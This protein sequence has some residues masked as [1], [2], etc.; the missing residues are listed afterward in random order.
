MFVLLFVD[1]P[2]RRAVVAVVALALAAC[3]EDAAPVAGQTGADT[4]DTPLDTSAPTD[5]GGGADTAVAELSLDIPKDVAVPVDAAKD[6]AAA[7]CP[8]CPCA[9]PDDC[10]SGFCI[11]SPNGLQCAKK[12]EDN[13]CPKDYKCASMPLGSGDL[14]NI[15]VPA[16]ANLCNPC[17]AN[18]QCQGPGSGGARCV[19]FGNAGA[20]C[21]EACTGNI[22]CLEGY[23]CLDTKDLAGNQSKQCVVKGGAACKCSPAALKY[24]L[25]TVCYKDTGSAKCAGKRICLGA[26]K[27]GAPTGGGLTP[28]L[29]DAP[30]AEKCDGKDNDC[31]GQTDESACDDGNP[32]TDDNCDPKA[33]CSHTNNNGFCDSDGSVCTKDDACANGKCLS[34]KPLNCDDNNV[35]TTDSCDAKSGCKNVNAEGLGCNVDDNPCTVGDACKEGKCVAGPPKACSNDQP[36]IE[37]KCNLFKGG[38]CEYKDKNGQPCDDGN[39]CTAGEACIADTCA[40]LKV[41]DCDDKNPCTIDTCDKKV[42]CTHTPAA[43]GCDDGDKCTTKDTCSNGKCD[44]AA[45]DASKYCNDNNGCTADTCNPA[46]GCVNKPNQGAACDDGNACSVGDKCDVT[47]SCLPGNNTCACTTDVDCVAMDDSNACNGV[48]YCDKSGPQMQCKIKP[49]SIVTCDTSGDNTC[50]KTVCDIATGKCAPNLQPDG[51]PCP[52]DDS[53]CTV[54]DGCKSGVCTAGKALACDDKNGCTIDTCDAKAGCQHAVQ[55][56]G[57]CDADGDACTTGDACKAGVCEAGAKKSC[58]DGEACTADTCDAK[59]GD[60]ANKPAATTTC[61]DGNECTIGDACGTDAKSGKY[62]CVPGKG[63]NCDDGNPCTTDTCDGKTGCKSTIVAD[64]Q[65]PC[66][67]GDPTTQ[68][69]GICKP[70]VQTC[71]A[72]GKLGACKG[73]VLPDKT[74][75]CDGKDN[76]CN[77]SAD[78]GCAP[79]GWGLRFANADVAGVG[80]NLAV[81][82][83]VGGGATA[84]KSA[85]SKYAVYWGFIA[86]LKG[87]VK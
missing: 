34:G 72:A 13:Q 17:T 18:T 41:T 62:T 46:V 70:G 52:F 44:G 32:C 83:V 22:D 1:R 27:P 77:G 73:E 63:P 14:V 50:K 11:E 38:V 49:G 2:A 28:C 6:G 47:G 64:A 55:Q 86:W 29:A 39:P 3:S 56:A 58:D 12:C 59:T 85:D 78:P 26:G 68:G 7:G 9:K 5:T 67:S 43:G 81:R 87:W 53:V 75:P 19:S 10:D 60:C 66:Y 74:D 16:H 35:C 36:C 40:S 65:V 84:G 31:D 69:K 30:E 61:S 42:G 20:F 15:C 82:A 79:G 48:L 24:E 51:L 57:P 54:D 4:V 45:I 71:D 23:E 76:D 25:H 37:G 33:D 21:G 80:P 8:G